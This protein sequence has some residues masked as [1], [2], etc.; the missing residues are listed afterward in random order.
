M[1]LQ[2]LKIEIENFR[3]YCHEKN[4]PIM[5][6]YLKEAYE[7]DPTTSYI[8]QVQAEWIDDIYNA[9]HFLTD[10]MFESM[11][12]E[13]REKVFSIKVFKKDDKLLGDSRQ[14]PVIVS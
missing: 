11:T 10:A 2:K 8:M 12:R 14:I 7:G 4:H 3:K 9:L 6:I 1:D 5:N 13:A